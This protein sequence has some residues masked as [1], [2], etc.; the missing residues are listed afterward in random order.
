MMRLWLAYVDDLYVAFDPELHCTPETSGY[1]MSY[2]QEAGGVCAVSIRRRQVGWAIMHPDAPRCAILSESPT[3]DPADAYVVARGRIVGVPGN[4]FDS[5]QT[6]EIA[7]APENLMDVADEREG[8][9]D[10]PLI[11]FAKSLPEDVGAFLASDA[12]ASDPATYI[13]GLS[14]DYYIDPATH[15]ISVND[16]IDGPLIDM[17]RSHIHDEKIRPTTEWADMPI[18]E[19]RHTIR[20]GWTQSAQGSV[21]IAER[22]HAAG[23]SRK[24]YTCSP[25]FLV[26]TMKELPGRMSIEAGNGWET[27]ISGILCREGSTNQFFTGRRGLVHYSVFAPGQPNYEAYREHKELA[28]LK[29]WRLDILS[30]FM[31]YDFSQEREEEI[32]VVTSMPLQTI[33]GVQGIQD[34]GEITTVDLLDDPTAEPYEPGAWAEGDRVE[35]GGMIWE[36][37]EDHTSLAFNQ[38]RPGQLL[39]DGQTINAHPYWKRVT[40]AAPIEASANGFATTDLGRKLIAHVVAR[41]RRLLLDRCRALR[42]TLTYPW[43]IAR[44]ITLKNRLRIETPWHDGS[45]RAIVGKVVR[46]EKSWSGDSGPLITVTI[47]VPLGTGANDTTELGLASGYGKATNY[48]RTRYLEP[49]LDPEVP[50]VYGAAGDTEFI[51]DAEDVPRT[52]DVHR[53]S[54]PFYSVVTCERRNEAAEQLAHAANRG[55][56]GLDPR[57]AVQQRPTKLGVRMINLTAEGV[58]RRDVFVAAEVLTSPRGIDLVDGGEP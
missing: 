50:E 26:E 31:N 56:Q 1:G 48:L 42:I 49:A 41:G 19:V 58:L 12:D 55:M 3:G 38:R 27:G 8:T 20:V 36:C 40:S 9:V 35:F 13:S 54:D 52:I 33:P 23:A 30:L 11:A 5:T 39:F 34:E 29:R 6:I 14:A 15:E 45:T 53:L 10:G 24:I 47:A 16:F 51:V 43:A 44:A 25:D 57:I 22:I 2:V 4:L 7:C 17:G 46:L 18:P 37:L 21:N 28:A 32:T